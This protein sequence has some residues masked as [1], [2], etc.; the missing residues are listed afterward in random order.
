[1]AALDLIESLSELRRMSRPSIPED[2]DDFMK[3]ERDIIGLLS[4]LSTTKLDEASISALRL[5]LPEVFALGSGFRGFVLDLFERLG[6][7]DESM[8]E[9][10]RRILEARGDRTSPYSMYTG[11]Y[12]QLLKILASAGSPIP[13]L[14]GPVYNLFET[15]LDDRPVGVGDTEMQLRAAELLLAWNG[16]EMLGPALDRRCDAPAFRNRVVELM[17]AEVD[18]KEY[19]IAN[20]E[21]FQKLYSRLSAVSAPFAQLVDRF[22]ERIRDG[23]KTLTC[24]RCGEYGVFVTYRGVPSEVIREPVACEQCGAELVLEI[25]WALQAPGH[26]EHEDISYTI[27]SNP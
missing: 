19:T 25:T 12:L 17:K 21:E 10:F 15:D 20:P 26:E 11:E 18:G 1:M 8:Q 4:R 6:P 22:H 16:P 3:M 2:Y 14:V 24:P 27:R 9:L 7:P 13:D 5:E 23:E